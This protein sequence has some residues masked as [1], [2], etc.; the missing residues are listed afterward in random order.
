MMN[1]EIRHFDT[2]V[3][4]FSA[5]EGADIN[6]SVM[7][8]TDDKS[9]LP[10]DLNGVS[11]GDVEA[12]LSQRTIPRNRAYVHSL[13]ASI[14]L[15]INRKMSIIN[16][17]KG[18]SLNDSYWVV[19]EGFDGSFE[20]YNL[21][22]NNFNNILGLI[23]FTGYG[24]MNVSRF[25]S[26]P[27]FTTNGMLP[28]CW[29][30]KNGIKLYKGGTQGASNTGNEPYSEYY[31]SQIAKILGFKAIDYTLSKWKSQLCSVCDLFTSKELAFIPI[32]RL[33]KSGG[34]KAVRK[35]YESL[36]TE[37][38]EALDEMIIFDAI[39]Y[40]TDRH[41]GNFG[42]LVNSRTNEIVKPAPL[43]D[44]GNSLF[45]LAGQVALENET[46]MEYYAKT[47]LPRVYDDFVLEAKPLLTHEHRN[48]LHQ[49]LNFRLKRHSRYNLDAKRLKLIEKQIS[50]R[51]REL[52]E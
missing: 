45:A 7:W 40:N 32:G 15:N 22:E 35:Y 29:R 2:T 11:A 5:S 52:L 47:Q 27:E 13:M 21:Y 6:L 12:W 51:V 37:F 50:K 48:K 42:V 30:R 49:L 18:L 10:L 16:I 39:I 46:G 25:A 38:V 44:H 28:K 4:R 24:S 23:A 1:Y 36:G 26:S 43:F 41:F 31:A 17:S 3:L 14:G 33:V 8:V 20:K 19:A 34:L 9:L